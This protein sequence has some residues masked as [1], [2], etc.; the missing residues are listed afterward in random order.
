MFN[1]LAALH[2]PALVALHNPRVK[3]LL[4]L[5]HNKLLMVAQVLLFVSV[6]LKGVQT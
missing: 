6:N 3:R 4:L 1:R 2:N 5:R